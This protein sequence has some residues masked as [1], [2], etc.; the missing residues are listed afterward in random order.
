VVPSLTTVILLLPLRAN[1]NPTFLFIY[2][3]TDGG[4]IQIN[5]PDYPCGRK[6]LG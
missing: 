5:P 2:Q 3:P 4:M 6:P 1:Q